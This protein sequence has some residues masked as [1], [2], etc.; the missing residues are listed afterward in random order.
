LGGQS[1]VHE[2]QAGT[3]QPSA[4]GRR[5]VQLIGAGAFVLGAVMAAASPS[6]VTGWL[7]LG[8]GFALAYKFRPPQ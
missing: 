5:I 1:Q 6:N 3:S 2:P 4:S 8:V 7:W